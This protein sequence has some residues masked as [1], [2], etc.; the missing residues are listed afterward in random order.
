MHLRLT[1][2]IKSEPTNE[3]RRRVRTPFAGAGCRLLVAGARRDA[4]FDGGTRLG[5]GG[6]MALAQPY[7]QNRS[8]GLRTANGF[9]QQAENDN[10]AGTIGNASRSRI[11]FL[12]PA[13]A[14]L[15]L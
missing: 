12:F 14:A 4:S 9:R 15:K 2:A 11:K 10:G 5:K 8:S 13:S 3:S 6:V 1:R 7:T